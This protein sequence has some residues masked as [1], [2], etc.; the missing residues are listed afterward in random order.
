MTSTMTLG[1][2]VSAFVAKRPHDASASARVL[3]LQLQAQRPRLARVMLPDLVR[4]PIAL[5][6][7]ALSSSTIGVPSIMTDILLALPALPALPALAAVQRFSD[8]DID[9]LVADIEEGPFS[10]VLSMRMAEAAEAVFGAALPN[11]TSGNIGWL[12]LRDLASDVHADVE[13]RR[14]AVHLLQVV[15]AITTALPLS[16][17]WPVLLSDPLAMVPERRAF[18]DVAGPRRGGIWR[19]FRTPILKTKGERS[20]TVWPEGSHGITIDLVELTIEAGAAFAQEAAWAVAYDI[21]NEPDDDDASLLRPEPSTTPRHGSSS[22]VPSR[23]VFVATPTASS[24]WREAP[25]VR[26]RRY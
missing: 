21:V 9:E 26:G 7:E 25:V 19:T 10:R 3:W 15:A 17:T 22:G 24:S 4:S 1:R 23:V 13:Q 8:I 6:V 14:K 2:A 11:L 12:R 16:P 18:L 20:L 5:T